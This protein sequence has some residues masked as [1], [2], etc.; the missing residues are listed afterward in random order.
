MENLEIMNSLKDAVKNWWA[1]LVLG[2]LF[3]IV[4]IW[5]MFT[6]LSSY[7]A[8]SILFAVFMFVSGIIE[9][10]FSVTNRKTLYGWGWYLSSGIFDFVIGFILLIY[11][12][13]TMLVLP[14]FVAFWLMFKGFSAI[15]F[16]IDIKRYGSKEWGYL[17]CLG[18]LVCLFS[19]LILIEPV[20]GGLSIV[21][22][23]AFAFLFIGIFRI[24]LSFRLRKLHKLHDSIQKD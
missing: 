2:I 9:I 14:F 17:L 21:Y 1:S 8:L 18:I 16:S 4:A 24:Y 7:L 10:I 13:I 12:Q 11:P 22:T 6:P 19:I 15:G 23:T 5:V 20:I 3:I